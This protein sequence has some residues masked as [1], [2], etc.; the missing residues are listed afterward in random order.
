MKSLCKWR[1]IGENIVNHIK[2][3][4][5]DFMQYDWY[6]HIERERAVHARPFRKI[7]KNYYY[8]LCMLFLSAYKIELISFQL[9][10]TIFI[11]CS[12]DF[13]KSHRL[14]YTQYIPYIY[15]S[16][17]RSHRWHNG[18]AISHKEHKKR[19]CASKIIGRKRVWETCAVPVSIKCAE[20]QSQ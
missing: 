12:S 9:P 7:R 13:H 14:A 4:I 3:N 15:I 6:L 1:S 11:R 2:L 18:N 5:L 19:K 20:V 17:N 16:L 8:A 10:S